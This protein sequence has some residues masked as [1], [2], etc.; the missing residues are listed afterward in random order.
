MTHFVFGPSWASKRRRAL[1][2]D[3]TSFCE[4]LQRGPCDFIITE[5]KIFSKVLGEFAEKSWRGRF[6]RDAD[7]FGEFRA[8][9]SFDLRIGRN[10][11]FFD[12]RADRL[13]E[14]T[15]LSKLVRS[16]ECDGVSFTTRASGA[17]DSVHVELWVLWKF[18]V[19]DER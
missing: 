4:K 5:P 16:H 10:Q 6:G 2:V 13:R 12:I 9:S 15:E 3:F 14:P 8:A 18:E 19:Y 1:E 17:T 11:V 7:R